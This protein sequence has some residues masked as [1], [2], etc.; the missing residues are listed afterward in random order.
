MPSTRAKKATKAAPKTRAQKWV[1]LFADGK[2]EGNANMRGLLGGT[3]RFT[4]YAVSL[5]A[6]G[7]SRILLCVLVV[8]I[9]LTSSTAYSLM[10]ALGGGF[11]VP[12]IGEAGPPIPPIGWS[13]GRKTLPARLSSRS[14]TSRRD[15]GVA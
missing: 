13:D 8:A 4:G 1:Y 9:G 10:F 5:T 11:A 3:R 12:P 14:R 7:L 15:C 6:E 2:A